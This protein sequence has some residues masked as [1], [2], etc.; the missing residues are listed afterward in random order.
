MTEP[1]TLRECPS[2][3]DGREPLIAHQISPR[4]CGQR[5]ADHYHKCHACQHLGVAGD[6]IVP[7]LKPLGGE[8]RPAPP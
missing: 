6:V 7:A 5:Q 4:L 2:P 3:V 8:L 1:N